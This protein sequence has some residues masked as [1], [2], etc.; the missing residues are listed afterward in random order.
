MINLN[1]YRKKI[2]SQATE[3][4]ITEKIFELIGTTNKKCVEFGVQ[5]GTQCCTKIMW[6]DKGF[7]QLMF[8]DKVENSAINLHKATITT[9]NVLELFRA[10]NIP[11]DLDLLCVDIDSYDFYVLHTILKEYTPRV[12]IVETNP[13]FLK[14][15]KV[16][17]LNHQTRGAYHGASCLAWFNSLNNKGYRLV[18]HEH[19]SINA[20]F[21]YGDLLKDQVEGWNNF[22]A[23]YNCP[24]APV[25]LDDY[26]KYPDTWPTFTSNEALNMIGQ[27]NENS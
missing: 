13:T 6:H 10:H 4:G 3:D 17:K 19:Y 14:E 27:S 25:N 2:Y 22:D 12:I 8:D 23:L 26:E 16:I 1:D 24:K 20:F 15:D 7:S 9:D 18:C 5:D 11:K 21:V